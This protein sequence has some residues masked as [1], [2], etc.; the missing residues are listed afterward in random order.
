MTANDWN[1]FDVSVDV[2]P[3]ADGAPQIVQDFARAQIGAMGSRLRAQFA[4]A[5]SRSFSRSSASAVSVANAA[6]RAV[7]A[8]HRVKIGLDVAAV[9]H[10]IIRV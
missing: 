1:R 4:A 3:E 2:R 9:S 6:R 8:S 10:G 5:T 7:S